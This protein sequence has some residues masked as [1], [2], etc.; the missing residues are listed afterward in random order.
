M[1]LGSSRHSSVLRLRRQFWVR[2]SSARVR[3]NLHSLRRRV[4]GKEKAKA[5]KKKRVARKKEITKIKVVAKRANRKQIL[6]RMRPNLPRKP[7]KRLDRKHSRQ[8]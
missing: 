8:N 3:L 6:K 2:S 7:R 1:W 4:K 5:R